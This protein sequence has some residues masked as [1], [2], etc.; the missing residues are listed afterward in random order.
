MKTPQ[1]ITVVIIFLAVLAV[2]VGAQGSSDED[3]IKKSQNPV[4]KMISLP[5]QN[6]TNFG[7]GTNSRMQNILNVQPVIP[8]TAGSVNIITRTIVPV[9][10][11]PDIAATSGG[12]FGLGDINSTIFFSPAVPGKIIWGVG[13]ILLFPTATDDMLGTG[14]FGVGPSG[15]ALTQTGRW[16]IGVIFNNIWSIAG[17]SDRADVNAFLT[18]PFVTYNLP[19]GWNV[20]TSPIIT[21]N[22][23][24][25]SDDRWL[26]PVGGGVGKLTRVGK[27]PVNFSAHGYYNV[28]HPESANVA[29]AD[30]T[31]RAQVQFLFPK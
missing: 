2:S 19:H 12:T 1:P 5:F 3:L 15:L 27:L 20:T 11:Q 4:A 18:Q 13:P 22:W 16:S 6:N 7:I 31:L 26:V 28:V 30:W 21:A 9:I 8:F 24:A 29:Y 10:Y 25:G 23:K 14:K 17:D